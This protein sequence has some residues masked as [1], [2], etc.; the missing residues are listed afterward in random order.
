MYYSGHDTKVKQRIFHQEP[1]GMILAVRNIT[2]YN[3]NTLNIF[4]INSYVKRIIDKRFRSIFIFRYVNVHVQ[5]L[6]I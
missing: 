3:F 2:T 1:N 5:K 6:S 4:F